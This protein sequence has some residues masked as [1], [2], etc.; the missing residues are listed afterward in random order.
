MGENDPLLVLVLNMSVVFAATNNFFVCLNKEI[1]FIYI[2]K[3]LL[4]NNKEVAVAAACLFIIN[5]HF[6]YI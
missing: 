5:K 3:K 6:N 4:F 2:F 1:L